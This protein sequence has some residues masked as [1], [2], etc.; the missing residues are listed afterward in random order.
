MESW[1]I[2]EPLA[3]NGTLISTASSITLVD[4]YLLIGS[5]IEKAISC[6]LND[7]LYA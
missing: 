3:N 1:V 6:H 2:T 5:R 7:P 4:D